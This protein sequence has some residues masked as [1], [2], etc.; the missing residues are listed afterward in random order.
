[1]SFPLYYLIIGHRSLVP[2]KISIARVN[3]AA[4]KYSGV[5]DALARASLTVTD[6]QQLY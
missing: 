3:R 4:E 2:N 1:M 5:D 6:N